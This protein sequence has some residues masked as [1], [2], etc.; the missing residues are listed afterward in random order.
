VPSTSDL[1]ARVARLE[2]LAMIADAPAPAAERVAFVEPRRECDHWH[3]GRRCGTHVIR[4]AD[5]RWWCPVCGHTRSLADTT[6]V[7]GATP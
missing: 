2:R 1:E 6:E 7:L 4:Y 3:N 5:G